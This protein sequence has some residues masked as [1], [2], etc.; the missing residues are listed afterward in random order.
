MS[1][2]FIGKAH[3]P[4]AEF[5][6][7]SADPEKC[8][9]CGR[10]VR[11]CPTHI[12]QLPEEGP[13]RIKGY[14][15]LEAA[16]LGCRNCEAV[17][18][19]GAVEVKGFYF[20]G[21]GRYR[22]T[23]AGRVELPNPFN[24]PEPPPFE[25]IE[26]RLTETERVILKR[27]S[28]RL[29]K[30]KAVPDELIRR[31]LEAAR[32]APSSGNGRAWEFLVIRDQDLIR[33]IETSCLKSLRLMSDNYLQPESRAARVLWNLFSLWRP[34]DMDVR[35]I[36]GMDTVVERDAIFFNAPVVIVVLADERG[37]GQPVLDAGISAQNLVIAA[38]AMGLGS[39]YVGF[40]T[41][42]NSRPDKRLM[43]EMGAMWP[44]RIATSIAL[45]FPRGRIDKVVP[46][47]RPKVVW[48]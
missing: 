21:E 6:R 2:K 18:P 42:L 44:M 11:T 28:N 29:F 34:G 25:K 40:I 12:I 1:M 36:S 4:P 27:R 48:K 47:D 43:E 32:Y 39:C 46:R 23:H 7:F 16:C 45:G 8:N 5:P 3:Y 14:K 24:D 19:E 13:P 35:V 30:K 38:H 17:C 33:R 41:A 26:E 22:S 15:G 10:C 31:C 20:V 9:R 37:I